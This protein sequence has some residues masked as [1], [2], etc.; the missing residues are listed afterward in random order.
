MVHDAGIAQELWDYNKRIYYY[1][2]FICVL[3][4]FA[5]WN[6]SIFTCYYCRT[7]TQSINSKHR[8]SVMQPKW[9]TKVIDEKKK[10]NF[11]LLKYLAISPRKIFN[12]TVSAM[13]SALCPVASLSTFNSAAP[14]SRAFR[15]KNSINTM[16]PRLKHIS[17][18]YD[19]GHIYYM[20][21]TE[22][23]N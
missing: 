20:E 23:N 1:L 16:K 4:R 18:N 14:L 17:A 5:S 12:R 7:S 19:S 15:R 8:F 10:K 6:W 9:G 21:W 3:E 13:S 2:L 11:L 22:A